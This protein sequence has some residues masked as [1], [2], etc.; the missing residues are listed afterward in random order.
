MVDGNSG[1]VGI[2]IGITRNIG[3]YNVILIT[4]YLL[5]DNTIIEL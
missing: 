5:G 1:Y 4:I 3:Y 2:E